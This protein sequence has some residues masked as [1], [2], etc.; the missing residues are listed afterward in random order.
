MAGNTWGRHFTVTTAGESHGF[1]YV[2]IIDGCPAGI[3]LDESDIQPAL[4]LRR[5]G[6]S[7]VVS[8]RREADTVK[9][10]SGVFEGKTTGA[11]IALLIENQ[12]A[13]SKDYDALKG[14]LRP[15]H[16]D[17]TY[18]A[19]HGVYDHRGG[20]R[21]SARETMM[22]VAAGAIAEKYLYQ[23][24]G[25]KCMAYLAQLGDI[26]IPITDFTM[27]SH[28]PFFVPDVTIVPRLEA[29]IQQIRAEKESIGARVTV[30]AEQ[31]PPGMGSPV[32]NG[33][34]ADIAQ[35]MMSIPAVKG[36][37]IGDGFN[38]I[39]QKGSDHRD[40]RTASGYLSNH[41]GGILGGISNGET[42]RV[43]IA[44]KPTSSVPKPAKTVDIANN[45]VISFVQ[46]RHDPCV[47]I[48]AVP[49]AK[50]MLALVLSDHLVAI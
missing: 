31:V 47:G 32:Y 21:A 34:D 35:A 46:G 26:A 28:N 13:R 49:V 9:I 38:V 43:S 23:Q 8:Q 14:V 42:I 29:Y 19:K 25:I 24:H 36:I 18:Y 2:A 20:G 6:R 27:V 45:E 44:I 15:G 17:A 22:R 33:L 37:E 10:I 41:A 11:S 1:A 39:T 12:D 30:F 50:A 40:E 16:A 48:R 5:P 3:D 7:S 4:D